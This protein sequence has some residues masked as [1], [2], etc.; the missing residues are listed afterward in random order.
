MLTLE[1]K[2]AGLQ[3]LLQTLDRVVV[4]FSGGVD[5]GYLL[6]ASVGALGD[7]AVGLT[8][9]SPSLAPEE[10]DTAV[11]VARQIGAR[12]VVIATDELDDARY[13]K[14]PVNRC[15]F[16]KTEVY[17]RAVAEAKKLGSAQ[18]LDGLNTD[19]RG[20]HRPG[21]QAAREQG[22]RSPLDELGFTKMD[23]RAAARRL[24]L[25]IWNKPALACLSSRFPYGVVITP[26]RLKRVADCEGVLRAPDFTVC[27]VRF[28][29]TMARIEVEST[30]IARLQTPD[31]WLQICR[32]FHQAGFDTV[33]ID[34]R[35]Y[36]PGSLNDRLVPAHDEPAAEPPATD[37]A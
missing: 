7:R 33:T 21:R 26:D 22:V 36:R 34:P 23:I 10:R 9:V 14:N 11:D 12:H 1:E 28:H 15:Y 19:D 8:A 24:G 30:E 37:H 27:R 16:C 31:I 35:G 6:A 13:T 5:S 18:V 17:S 20:D 29:D 32:E 2:I 3:Q 25:P 4:C